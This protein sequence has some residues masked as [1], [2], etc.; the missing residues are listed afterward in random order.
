MNEAYLNFEFRISNFESSNSF[1]RHSKFDIR[2]LLSSPVFHDHIARA[3]VATRLIAACRLSP[4]RYRVASAG[5]LSF[6]AAMRVI[7]RVHRNSAYFRALAF[8]AVA[9]RFSER[10]VLVLGVSNLSD[11]CVANHRHLSNFA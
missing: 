9:T 10:Y 6:T 3:F 7:D 8:P 5:R 4:G 1:I 2:H 11:G